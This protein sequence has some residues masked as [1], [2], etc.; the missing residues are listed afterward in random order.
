V[1]EEHCKERTN[2]VGDCFSS[3]S[4]IVVVDDDVERK[5]QMRER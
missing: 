2:V 3:S 4:W 1:L 5:V